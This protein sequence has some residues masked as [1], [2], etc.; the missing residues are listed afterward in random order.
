MNSYNVEKRLIE[1]DFVKSSLRHGVRIPRTEAY[2]AV[3][4]SDGG[5]SANEHQGL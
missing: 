4:C 1:D 2:C 3:R 5:R